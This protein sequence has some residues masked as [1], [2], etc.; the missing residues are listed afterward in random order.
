MRALR[1][2]ALALTIIGAINWGLIGLFEFDLVASI[3]GGQ[4]A[5]IS[6]LIYTLVGLSGLICLSYFFDQQETVDDTETYTSPI[7][8]ERATTGVRPNYG[9][10][11]AEDPDLDLAFNPSRDSYRKDDEEE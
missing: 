6:R 4:T 11:F 9:M 8:D 7:Q 5:G 3:F 10:E 1:R 2:I